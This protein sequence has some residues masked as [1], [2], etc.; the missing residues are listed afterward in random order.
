M[1]AIDRFR[2]LHAAGTFVMPN[3]WDIGSARLLEHLGFLALATTSSGHAG[4]LGRLDQHVRRDELVA[5]AEAVAQCG[6]RAAERR[7]RGT[8]SPTSPAAWRAR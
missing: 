4:S 3:P 7:R 6:R 5:H 2:D 1:S 8:A